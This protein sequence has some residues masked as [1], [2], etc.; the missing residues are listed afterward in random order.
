MYA[1][2][3][4]FE[5]LIFI[6]VLVV[7]SIL[8]GISIITQKRLKKFNLNK[9]LKIQMLMAE[10]YVFNHNIKIQCSIRTYIHNFFEL[11]QKFKMSKE[12][13]DNVYN[14]LYKKKFIHKLAKNVSS[15]N[16]FKR[17]QAITYLSL[18]QNEKTKKIFC[19]ILNFE[20]K[21][22]IK[23]LI[24]NGLKYDLDANV[25]RHIITSLLGSKRN[26]QKRVIKILTKYINQSE[27]DLSLQ[28]N[29]PLIEVRETF[30]EI[31]QEVYHPNFEKPLYDNL[32][33]IEKHFLFENSA[34]FR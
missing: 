15:R 29:S 27:H 12:S 14:Y 10:K 20:Q 31:A 9:K 28:L 21:D 3:G 25:V 7:G 1:A 30:V 8:L 11:S 18:F 16:E 5:V 2:I 4:Y 32:R 33:E 17:V 6:G 34:F 22:Y 19:D 23:I 13:L 24:V 26:Y